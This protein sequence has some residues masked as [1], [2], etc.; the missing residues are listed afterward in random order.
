MFFLSLIAYLFFLYLGLSWAMGN[1]PPASMASL[2][3]VRGNTVRA[4]EVLQHLKELI[5]RHKQF[6]IE[7]SRAE[8]DIPHYKFYTGMI[9]LALR[10]SVQFGAPIG[11]HLKSLRKS[12]IQD[13]EFERKLSGH[14]FSTLG[15]VLTLSLI[16][17]GFGLFCRGILGLWPPWTDMLVVGMLQFFGAGIFLFIYRRKKTSLFFPYE[18]CYYSLV[19][20]AI[21]QQLGLSLQQVVA[22][23]GIEELPEKGRLAGVRS[24]LQSLFRQCHHRGHS[25]KDFVVELR[26]EV[27][28]YLEEDFKKFL[29][30][31][32]RM[33]FLVLAAFY[34]P[35][36]LIFVFSLFGDLVPHSP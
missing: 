5:S 14:L 6:K 32:T 23:C 18:K 9:Q 20:A 26:E 3:A 28:F 11:E 24:Q 27:D 2:K 16:T 1:L 7:N 8:L 34:L 4:K 30:F 33:K 15:Q 10:Y 35:A 19:S 31:T 17:W 21:L 25:L 36:Y 12:L 13:W 22:R 29:Q